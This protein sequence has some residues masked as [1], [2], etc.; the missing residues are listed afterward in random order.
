MSPIPAPDYRTDNQRIIKAS[1]RFIGFGNLTIKSQLYLNPLF[2][3]T[4]EEAFLM[5]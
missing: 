5:M 3:Q 2:E 4:E 1:T